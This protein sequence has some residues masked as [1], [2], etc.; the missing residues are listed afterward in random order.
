MATTS[1][2]VKIQV[3]DEVI[4]L[5]GDDLIAFEADRAAI[6]A[7]EA[8]I[9]AEI[10]AKQAAKEAALAKLGLTPEEVAAILS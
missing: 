2:E 6:V 4:I 1:K 9:R 5:S 3:A 8:S 7:H 10:L